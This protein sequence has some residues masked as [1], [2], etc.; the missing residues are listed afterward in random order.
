[1]ERPLIEIKTVKKVMGISNLSELKKFK[2]S[3]VC[4]SKA[5]IKK[6]KDF[7]QKD[8]AERQLKEYIRLI[9]NRRH[10]LLSVVENK[11][12]IHDLS[13]LDENFQTIMQDIHF[14]LLNT[15]MP[16]QWGSKIKAQTKLKH[17]KTRIKA[18]TEEDKLKMTHY[19]EISEK[20]LRDS[21]KRLLKDKKKLL[22][23]KV[24]DKEK[25]G[26]LN[27][28]ID[29]VVIALDH[30]SLIRMVRNWEQ[31]RRRA[32][33]RVYKVLGGLEGLYQ[34]Q[35]NI[36]N[37]WKKLTGDKNVLCGRLFLKSNARLFIL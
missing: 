27:K 33:D 22:Q 18:Y 9:D 26:T 28:K 2:A 15:I 7:K 12:Q 37:S 31:K 17:K 16:E 13:N 4:K 34:Y 5:K 19:K 21:H 32:L 20:G 11:K 10:D 30:Y 23:E 8:G 36:N 14:V 1:M 25:L 29:A 6:L 24:I 35:K 3:F